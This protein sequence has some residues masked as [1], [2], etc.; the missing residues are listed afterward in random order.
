MSP[1]NSI[2]ETPKSKHVLELSRP[3]KAAGDHRFRHH[4]DL[5][6]IKPGTKQYDPDF[7]KPISLS[8]TGYEAVAWRS[9]DVL[10]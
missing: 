7:P 3:K 2:P 6:R 8:A 1:D 9:D 4:I 5:V 10:A